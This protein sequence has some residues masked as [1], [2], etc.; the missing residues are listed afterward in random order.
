MHTCSKCGL[1]AE[2]PHVKEGDCIAVLR[3]ALKSRTDEV[4]QLQEA[5]RAD[6][7]KIAAS[8][9]VVG[10]VARGVVF[11]GDGFCSCFFCFCRAK[12]TNGLSATDWSKVLAD[13]K[14]DP[15]CLTLR[16]R[17]IFTKKD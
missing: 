9:A 15:E 1:L 17:K 10:Q 12:L 11:A 4:Q 8:A 5:A 16:A 2:T 6:A 14:H 13:F 7:K 3:W